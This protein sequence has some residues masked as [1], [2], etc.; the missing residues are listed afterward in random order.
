MAVVVD[1][2]APNPTPSA[3]VTSSDGFLTVTV[4]PAF[5]GALL[6]AHF[7]SLNPDPFAVMFVRGDGLRVR[8][9]DSRRS[10][11]G[12]A[13]AYDHEAPLGETSS[14]TA[15]PLDRDGVAGTSSTGA[16]VA[17]PDPTGSRLWVNSIDSPSLSMLLTVTAPVVSWSHQGR[18]SF[19]T[20]PGNPYP[21][22]S[23]DVP[24]AREGSLAF[25][26][27]TLAERDS[28]VALLASGPLL[29]QAKSA[30]GWGQCYVLPTGYEEGSGPSGVQDVRRMWAVSVTEIA[31]P[32]T[33][34]CALFIPGKSYADTLVLAATYT[35][36]AATWPLYA[37]ILEP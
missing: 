18:V 31:R 12:Y 16:A 14:W 24:A 21:A 25:L 11:G 9:G 2:L 22:G 27:S 10:P 1:P 15:I 30:W 36:S 33:L 32:A 7:S 34:D 37:N 28:L 6:Q 13:T 35:A 3:S 26:T 23:W 19:A 5:G 20:V 4:D 8:S 17:L 29:L